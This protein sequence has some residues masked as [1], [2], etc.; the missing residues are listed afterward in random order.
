LESLSVPL[1]DIWRD[2]AQEILLNSPQLRSLHILKGGT[3]LS[4]L[5]FPKQSRLD[6][7]QILAV[8]YL[9]R[10]LSTPILDILKLSPLHTVVVA[11][12]EHDHLHTSWLEPIITHLRESPNLKHLNLCSYS[13]LDLKGGGFD[14]LESLR[15]L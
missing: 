2:L 3:E 1:D 13:Q 7:L 10:D 12:V 4:P 8:D 9:K 15:I 6:K 11:A 5:I 14:S